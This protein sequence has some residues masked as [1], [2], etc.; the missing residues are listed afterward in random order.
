MRRV[1][2]NCPLIVLFF[3]LLAAPQL[4][5]AQYCTP[6]YS[7]SCLSSNDYINN[8]SF[9]T[10]LNN[11][12][13]CNG[14]VNNYINYPPTGTFTTS[15]ESGASYSIGMQSGILWP[16]GF[17]IWI[18]FNNDNDFDDNDEFVY[19]S[20]T[21]GINQFTG[22][23]TIPSN[24]AYLGDRRMRVRCKFSG[25]V[26]SFESCSTFNYGETEDYTVSIVPAVT[27][28]SY[29]SSTVTQNNLN[30]VGLGESSVEIIGI[31]VITSGSA[32]PLA[33]TSC[34]LNSNG[35]TNFSNDVTGVKVYFTG[36]SPVFSTGQLYATV[37][38][39]SVPVTVNAI[40]AS[41]TNYFWVAYDVSPTA[42]AGDK[43]DA[44]CTQLLFT[45]STGIQIPSVTAPDGFREINYCFPSYTESCTSGDFID[46]V[47][48]NTLTNAGSGC[49]GNNNNYI[50]YPP[51]GNLT[52][53]VEL[54]KNYTIALQ[55]GIGFNQGF[56]VWIDYNNDLDFADAD[57][58][59]YASASTG[60]S[61]FV[62]SITIP[63]NAAY[64]GEHLMRVRCI[65]NNVPAAGDFCNNQNR[66]ETED[67]RISISQ[68]FAM[69][70]QSSTTI[71]N[72]SGDVL[73]GSVDQE[74]IAVEVVVSGSN[75]PLNVTALTINSN[76]TTDFANDVTNVKIYYTGSNPVFAT[77]TLF[78][79]ATDLSNPVTGIA[80][81]VSG[82]NHFWIT[83]DISPTATIGN[84]TD[85]ECTKVL[86]S[87]GG[88]KVPQVT[89]PAGNRQI[90]YCT[91]S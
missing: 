90:G 12:S 5:P 86:L 79:A 38:D 4:A 80:G 62:G 50:S 54:G 37:T 59:V 42:F 40:L 46:Y 15:V 24:P 63:N 44:A 33:L 58:F 20:P 89:A 30:P 27:S 22:S 47:S 78:G 19:A 39:L 56:G 7:N 64:T 85:A 11:G 84:Y 83:Y 60:T 10:L 52:T 6:L 17:G 23:V 82:I 9:H 26:S 66:G 53:T 21:I 87:V 35:S 2:Y 55:A 13:G 8:F 28:M 36:N 18:D 34:T 73:I 61:L 67:Y 16:E 32:N 1:I 14:N 25:I 3:L 91:A 77:N 68:P 71:Q 74:I 43:I 81:L 49:N 70:Y 45:G 75:N 41:G 69:V 57:E 76:G 65:Y 72:N 48:F 88:E 51:A 29:V 31:Q